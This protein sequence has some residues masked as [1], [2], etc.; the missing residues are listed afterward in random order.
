MPD[1]HT[2]GLSECYLQKLIALHI[3]A[4]VLVPLISGGSLW[5]LLQVSESEQ[6]R[7]WQLQEVEFLKAVAVQL[8][9]A[10]QQ[11]ST[12][13]LLAASE[14]RLRL[15][16]KAADQGLF[17]VNVQTGQA[18]V[19]PE[20]ALMLGYDPAD[21]AESHQSWLGRIHPDDVEIVCRAYQDYVGG[22]S[23]T[24]KV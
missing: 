5:G 3:R 23:T 22:K 16:L 20:Y 18:T 12:T 21:F 19:S 6:A 17:D 14:E 1:I 9:I 7:A 15:A 13:A 11:A 10:L 24:Y 8:G 4:K 2:S